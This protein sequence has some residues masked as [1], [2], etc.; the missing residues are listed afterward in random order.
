MIVPLQEVVW[1]PQ[2]FQ[3]TIDGYKRWAEVTNTVAFITRCPGVDVM[4]MLENMYAALPS[5]MTIIPCLKPLLP[6]DG[7][8]S[9][10]LDN[11]RCW[12]GLANMFGML[13]TRCGGCRRARSTIVGLDLESASKRWVVKHEG[14]L[15]LR[16][17]YEDCVPKLVLSGADEVWIHPSVFCKATDPTVRDRSAALCRAIELG[18]KQK[19]DRP[20]IRWISQRVQGPEVCENPALYA[21][22]QAD[23]EALRSFAA[24]IPVAIQYY[25]ANKPG[26]RK[27]WLPTEIRQAVG[28]ARRYRMDIQI[29]YPGNDSPTGIGRWTAATEVIVAELKR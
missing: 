6:A 25:Y 15:D 8:Q 28:A 9:P 2:H 11:P 5:T 22:Y 3:A 27:W 16:R 1:P 19:A 14:A 12:E 20:R 21:M 26:E 13:T 10:Q 4:A 17:I 23:S 24:E 7:G 18:L 29:V